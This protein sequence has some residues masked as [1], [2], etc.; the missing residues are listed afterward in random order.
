MTRLNHKNTTN[1]SLSSKQPERIAYAK[2]IVTHKKRASG[3]HNSQG[4]QNK[5]HKSELHI[6]SQKYGI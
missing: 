1:T 4:S 3:G 5:T 2:P 6:Y